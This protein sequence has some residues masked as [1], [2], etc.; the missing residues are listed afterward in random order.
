MT[1]RKGASKRLKKSYNK[2]KDHL[3]GEDLHQI[4]ESGNLI[5]LIN[6]YIHDIRYPWIKWNQPIGLLRI[7]TL[8][9]DYGHRTKLFD[10]L[11]P[12]KEG[13]IRK[14]KIG[15]IKRDEFKLNIW[16]Y[17]IQ[18][19]QLRNSFKKIE[20][21]PKEIW[22][23]CMV[24]YWWKSVHEIVQMCRK[25]FSKAHIIL[26]GAYPTL[27]TEHAKENFDI[28]QV[29]KGEQVCVHLEDGFKADTIV[30]GWIP[31][32]FDRYPD[33]TLYKRMPR[34]A[35]INATKIENSVFKDPYRVFSEIKTISNIFGIRNFVFFDDNLLFNKGKHLKRI[36]DIIIQKNLKIRFWGLHGINSNEITESAILKMKKAGFRMITLECSYKQNI[37]LD[38][39]REAIRLITKAGYR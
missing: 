13:I 2:A 38:P 3:A 34:F 5:L 16:N 4:S 8:L 31:Q 11:R 18:K 15:D 35:A 33:F 32:A 17:G 37:D 36:L 22:I 7:S 27:F 21:E 1:S 29:C 6:P 28:S 20:E 26:G 10:C 30:T 39:Y 24:G 25:H 19:Y 9:K 23:T 12:D 14:R